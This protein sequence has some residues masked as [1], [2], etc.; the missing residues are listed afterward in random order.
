MKSI[1]VQLPSVLCFALWASMSSV[2]VHAAT[3]DSSTDSQGPS[4]GLEE[5]TVTAQ[6]REESVTRV[7]ISIAAFTQADL[8]A[9]H[10]ES[11]G[12]IASVTPGLDF[13]P[14]GY[15]N[16]IA[17][18][19]ISQDAGG[20]VAG[21]G[22]STTA[23][24][25]DDAPLQARYA[26]AAVP[27]AIPL[28]FDVDH[29]EVLRGPQGTLFGASAE[30]GA[31]RV[32]S[33]EPSLTD[34]SG[35]ARAEESSIDGGGINS[36]VGA[37]FGGPIVPDQLGF[38]V[39]VWSRHDG[40]YVNNESSIF[41]GL[42]QPNVNK[43]D[44]Y[45]AQA[46]LLW[47]PVD[48]FSAE[49]RFFYQKRDQNSADFFNPLAGNPND[50]DFV[51][52]R[53]LIQ[54]INDTFN[55]PSLKLIGDLGWAQVTSITTNLHREDA[56]G[57]D[58]TTVLPPAFGFPV[59]TSM[60]YAEPTIVGTTQNNFTQDIRLQSPS[61][62]ERFIWLL[63]LYY[64]SLHQHDHETV[65][66]LGFPAEVLQYTGETLLQDLGENLVGNGDSYIS[67]QYFDDK[68]KAVYGH[69]EYEIGGHVSVVGGLRYE[70][71]NST[72]LTVSDG[73]VA[74]G[75]SNI[76]G[77][78]SNSVTAPQAGINWKPD[79]NT[80]VYIS[81]AKGYRPGGVNI[82][83][84]LTTSACTDQL[85]ALGDTSTYNPDTLWSY[86]VGAKLLFFDRRLAV[87][88]S[89]YHITWN[90]II[91]S[92]AV[93]ACAT[94]VSANLGDARSNGFDLSLKAL[95]TQHWSVGATVGYTDAYYTTT[96]SRFG[97]I[98]ARSGE[99]IS[100]VSPW[101][102][103]A[104]L[105][106]QTTLRTGLDGY[107]SLEDRFSSRNNRLV[108]AED[109][110]TESYDPSV[111]TNPSI[112]QVN[113]RI[114][115]RVDGADVSLFATNLLNAH[116]LLNEYLGLIDITSGAFTIVPRTVGV[117]VLYHW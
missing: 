15:E 44:T 23:I 72:Y 63:G 52:T 40:G 105:Q 81:A 2:V 71:E 114:G 31:I 80:L 3:P 39:S 50:G 28:V 8:D 109:V 100:D 60:N 68:E 102:L 87:D 95:I 34:Y 33:R 86:E 67:D 58:Y 22:P 97:E 47:K 21:L 26:N 1:G 16:W 11:V 91:S 66:A 106:Y 20:G 69:A 65:Q 19:G 4:S 12:D 73:P 35:V 5:I 108:P 46:A 32:I 85:A 37:A 57:Y 64:S 93:P 92:I 77:E 54:P 74:G 30:G 56:Q 10:L 45:V 76:G 18:R 38:R 29:V 51:S 112:N 116:P 94:H 42:N 111:T 43:G 41:G 55:T 83:V 24:Y 7:P 103:T 59:P 70:K 101:D 96:T 49:A 75:P 48:A 89:V 84:H 115:I 78:V 88:G 13:R 107:G 113:A 17:I 117:A 82:P 99:A 90:D 104:N 61:S 53:S 62:N 27:T 14:V 9:R 98:L 36:E 6:R 110:S 25:V 79:D